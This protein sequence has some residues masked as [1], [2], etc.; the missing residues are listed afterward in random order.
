M[1]DSQAVLAAISNPS[2]HIMKNKLITNIL[3]K[4]IKL[5]TLNKQVIFIW[6]K[7]HSGIVG[8]ETVDS[9]A[10]TAKGP[11]IEYLPYQDLVTNARMDMKKKWE[12]E[13]IQ[14]SQTHN[15]QYCRI[16]NR[17]PP[18]PAIFY[19]PYNRQL[20]ITYI[21]CLFGHGAFK[22]T[23]FKMK[24]VDSPLCDCD[25]NTADINHWLFQC[26]NNLPAINFLKNKLLEV[27]TLTPLDSTS[28]LYAVTQDEKCRNI[29]LEFIRLCR[30]R[31]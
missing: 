2:K 23:L 16:Y 19:F 9:L 30:V 4:V 8:N 29:F 28:L 18:K 10:K 13:W 24:L 17:L 20:F 14:I 25:G 21:R 1:S 3:E 12:E 31:I 6:V 11:V 15:Y 26:G 22:A 27:G 5:G 7:G